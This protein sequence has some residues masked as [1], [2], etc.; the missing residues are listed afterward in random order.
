[1]ATAANP[2][3]PQANLY[4]QQQPAAYTQMAQQ[5]AAAAQSDEQARAQAWETYFKQHPEDP[6]AKPFLDQLAASRSQQPPPPQPFQQQ[7]Q[8]PYHQYHQQQQQ[9]YQQQQ[10][11]QP[12]QQQMQQQ[13]QPHQRQQQP[14]PPSHTGQQQQQQQQQYNAVPPPPSLAARSSSSGS[15][16]SY[17]APVSAVSASAM[18]VALAG[19]RGGPGTAVAASVAAGPNAGATGGGGSG[20]SGAAPGSNSG[21]GDG[22]GAAGGGAGPGGWPA[23]LRAYVER[24]FKVAEGVSGGKQRVEAHLKRLITESVERNDMWSR[25]WAQTPLPVL[26]GMAQGQQ[27]Q[28]PCWVDKRTHRPEQEQQQQQQQQ[29]KLTKKQQKKRKLQQQ[30]QPGHWE[31]EAEADAMQPRA[32]SE[33]IAKRRERLQRFERLEEEQGGGGGAHKRRHGAPDGGDGGGGGAV[34]AGAHQKAAAYTD[35]GGLDFEAMTVQGTCRVVEKDYFR[36]TSA[37]DPARVRPP[38]VLEQALALMQ[39][40]WRHAPPEAPRSCDYKYICNQFKGIRQDLRVQNITDGL[41]VR[42]YETHARVA[43]EQQDMNEFNQCQTQLKDLYKLGVPS[44]HQF[45]FLAYRILYHVYTQGKNQRKGTD[46]SFDIAAVLL[47][48]Q[49]SA[50]ASEHPAVVHALEVR[51]AK[52]A[53]NY[54]SYFRLA[55]ATPNMGRLLMAATYNSQREAA[56]K[57]I[58]KAYRP[59]VQGSFLQETLLFGSLADTLAY[60]K[61]N[62]IADA[63]I[64]EREGDFLVDAKAAHGTFRVSQEAGTRLI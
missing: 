33:E 29:Q 58:L 26:H 14:P 28:A 35:E 63:D 51:K 22:G 27:Q 62:G 42:V 3:A 45:E 44:K 13:Y 60:C 48:V 54:C 5:P 49:R 61:K 52:A 46:G 53:D 32:T 6:R 19:R 36:L 21:S 38:A 43:L 8:Q 20:G 59:H 23:A 2:Y 9:P 39:Q 40:K 64:S 15:A 12:P 11:C 41:T 31:A 30:Q 10:H 37:P 16:A 56:M 1:M 55:R 7:Q 17:R 34:F 57:H 47:E 18:Q 4:A 50:E 25:D 24:C